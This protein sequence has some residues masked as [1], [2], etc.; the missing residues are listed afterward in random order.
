LISQN[1]QTSTTGIVNNTKYFHLVAN[2]KHRKKKIFQLE[3]EEGTIIGQDK[4]RTYISEYYKNLFGEPTHSNSEM[5][6]ANIGDIPQLSQ[7]V[8]N[9]LTADFTEK[10]V[11][12]AI[13]KM[14]KN[15]APGPGSWQ[16][17]IKKLGFY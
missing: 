12:D 13:M 15:K 10:E 6:E 2:G 11:H 1:S 4:L 5:I 14:E 16:N 7:E 17:S 9:I 3:Q 8:N